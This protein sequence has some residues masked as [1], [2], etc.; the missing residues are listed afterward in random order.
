[1]KRLLGLARQKNALAVLL[2]TENSEVGTRFGGVWV[3]E[4]DQ[5]MGFGKT[6][7]PLSHRGLHFTGF[8]ILSDRVFDFFRVDQAA[9]N[10]LYDA[11]TD[12]ISKGEKVLAVCEP[13]L[14][15]EVGN[16]ADFIEASRH[17]L[18]QLRSKSNAGLVSLA[19]A[20]WSDFAKRTDV[21][22]PAEGNLEWS[23]RFADLS[24]LIGSGVEARGY[25]TLTDHVVL[26]ADTKLGKDCQ[27]KNSIVQRGVALPA[28]SNLEDALIS[29][30]G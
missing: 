7:W 10:I 27:L 2:T 16:P 26:G 17:L 15:M 18:Q 25:P 13:G 29:K 11:L 5:V 1:M 3:D 8:M 20:Y 19:S 21:R 6:K 30:I 23:Q 28:G 4:Q 9:P 22:F 24:V 12:G 14:W